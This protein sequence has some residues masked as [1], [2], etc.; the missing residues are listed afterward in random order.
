MGR[1][2]KILIL[3]CFALV[4]MTSPAIA[5]LGTTAEVIDQSSVVTMDADVQSAEVISTAAPLSFVIDAMENR[6]SS[7]VSEVGDCR[8]AVRAPCRTKHDSL[9]DSTNQRGACTRTWYTPTCDDLRDD[10][11]GFVLKDK[12]QGRPQ[13]E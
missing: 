4:L 6:P 1:V 9:M 5:D 3:I 11:A 8:G 7:G 12:K 2:L 10:C 13:L